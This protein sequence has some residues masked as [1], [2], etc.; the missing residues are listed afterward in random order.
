MTTDDTTGKL[1]LGFLLAQ[2]SN[3]LI[4]HFRQG[5][6]LCRID[7]V[8]TDDVIA[9][10]GLDRTTDLVRLH[11]E[12]SLLEGLTKAQKKLNWELASTLHV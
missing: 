2:F 4:A 8:E 11:A 10:V 9:E 7:A 3:D 6:N 5:L 12:H 1:L